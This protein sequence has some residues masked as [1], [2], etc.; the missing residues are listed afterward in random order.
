[1]QH[2]MPAVS[3]DGVR[4]NAMGMKAWM[5]S[6][7]TPMCRPLDITLKIVFHPTGVF[8]SASRLFVR[9]YRMS[10]TISMRVNCDTGDS[11]QRLENHARNVQAGG[12]GFCVSTAL[13]AM[14]AFHT[15]HIFTNVF[16]GSIQFCR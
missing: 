7:L 16:Q 8:K 5:I 9:P 1:M 4:V 11:R 15:R 10:Q 12:G 13:F 2:C 3:L 14:F 6:G